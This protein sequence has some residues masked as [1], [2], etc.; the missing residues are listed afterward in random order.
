MAAEARNVKN[1]ARSRPTSGIMNMALGALK[2]LFG[3][4]NA[5]ADAL[6]A[7]LVE[8]ARTPHFYAD[9]GVPDTIDGRFDMLALMLSAAIVRLEA[10]GAPTLPLRTR[11]REVFVEDMDESMREIG[12]GDLGVGKHVKKMMVAFEGRFLVYREALPAGNADLLAQLIARN[13][14]RGAAENKAEQL[15]AHVR[16]MADR[17]QA[18]P[19]DRFSVGDLSA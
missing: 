16:A 9:L 18:A 11:L 1:I 6:Y 13:V 14:Y 7:A 2:R 3:G 15:A 10:G 8:A 4:R 19:L 5:Q 12:V 17:W